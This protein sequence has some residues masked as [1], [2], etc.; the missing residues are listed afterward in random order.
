MDADT[1]AQISQLNAQIRELKKQKSSL[2]WGATPNKTNDKH[3]DRYSKMSRF[4]DEY[5]K[6]E[7][8][9]AKA[10]GK[11]N[12]ITM[13]MI[14]FITEKK[15][16][17]HFI[18]PE[19]NQ[20]FN[21]YIEATD[22]HKDFQTM[23]DWAQERSNEMNRPV[24]FYKKINCEFKFDFKYCPEKEPEEKLE[25]PIC[26]SEKLETNF[27]A[28][29]CGGNHKICKTCIKKHK[30]T[31]RRHNMNMK[32]PMCNHSFGR[33][34]QEKDCWNNITISDRY[35]NGNSI[36]PQVIIDSDDDE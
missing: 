20:A 25:C 15:N 14:D 17:Y 27:V 18:N 24:E 13:E 9:K 12:T 21:D 23:R 22:K 31:M 16:Y 8:G 26:Y 34:P 1:Q 28:I 30:D 3:F 35:R 6:D 2:K 33:N 5:G 32:C 4:L 29:K 7:N 19:D 10:K 36:T 11:R